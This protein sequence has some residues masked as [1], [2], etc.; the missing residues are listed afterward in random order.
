[1]MRCSSF[2]GMLRESRYARMSAC[3]VSQLRTQPMS[4]EFGD[5]GIT[6]KRAIDKLRSDVA[7]SAASRLFTRPK[8]CMTRSSCRRS[9][10]PLSRN[11]Y[12]L[13]SLP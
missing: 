11:W 10:W 1:M 6:A 13:P 5:R 2:S 7:R 4:P 9:S 8:S 12:S 3:S